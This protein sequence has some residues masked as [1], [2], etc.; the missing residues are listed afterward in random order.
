MPETDYVDALSVLAIDHRP[1]IEVVPDALGGLHSATQL[2]APVRAT[3]FRGRDAMD[4]IAAADGWHWESAL[5]LRDTSVVE[6]IRDGLELAFVRPPHAATAT[7]VLDA[8]NTPW[9]GHLKNEYIGAHGSSTRAWYDSLD[10]DAALVTQLAERMIREAYLVAWV[11]VEDRW[12]RQ[13]FLWEAGPEVGKRHAVP[14][15]LAGVTRDT[16]LVRL[17]SVPSFWLIDYAAIDYSK[18]HT[19]SSHEVKLD[20]VVAVGNDEIRAKLETQDRRYVVLQR[21][22]Y[23]DLE[24]R[25]PAV[26]AGMTRSYLLKSSGWYRVHTDQ[27]AAPQVALLR[28]AETEAYGI[29]KI[30][31]ARLNDV[32]TGLERSDK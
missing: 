25:V 7:L 15:D 2:H 18:P 19:L 6:D 5:S 23:Y 11:W 10:T 29:S 28:K 1:G 3:D 8:T 14:L 4:R 30:S 32:L 9:A 26:P 12:Q 24:F 21:G 22:D 17:E 27:A 31:V 13:G 16:V 20:R